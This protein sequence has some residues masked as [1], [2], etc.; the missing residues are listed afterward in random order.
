M[1]RQSSLVALVA[2]TVLVLVDPVLAGWDFVTP[3]FEASFT[4]NS[5]IAFTGNGRTNGVAFSVYFKK[6]DVTEQST[7]GTCGMMGYWGG[8]LDCPSGGWS[9][10]GATEFHEIWVYP[11]GAD[12]A[13][14]NIKIVNSN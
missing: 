10:D 14:R 7:S 13:G 4:K 1:V 5:D 8:E 2:F 6:N 12:N 9:V 3:S 11:T